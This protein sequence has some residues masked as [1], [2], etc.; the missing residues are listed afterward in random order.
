MR[1]IGA[2]III[3]IIFLGIAAYEINARVLLNIPWNGIEPAANKFAI[4]V[5][6]IWVV[7][8]IAAWSGSSITRIFAIGSA[9]FILLMHTLIILTGGNE[10]GRIFF[11]VTLLLA[12]AIYAGSLFSSE[13]ACRLERDSQKI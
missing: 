4:V 9:T 7:G 5:G 8:A 2:K 3:S 1:E 13:E 12:V 10:Y 11:L 6:L